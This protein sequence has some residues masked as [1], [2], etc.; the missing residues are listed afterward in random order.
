M[1]KKD[2]II[3]IGS[4]NMDVAGYSHGVLNYA[5]STRVK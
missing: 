4:A 1:R 2:Y 3:T 5:D